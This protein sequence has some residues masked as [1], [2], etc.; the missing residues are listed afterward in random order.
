MSEAR[1]EAQLAA[2]VDLGF[3]RSEAVLIVADERRR[4]MV[5]ARDAGAKQREIAASLGISANCVRQY[6]ERARRMAGPWGRSNPAERLAQLGGSEVAILTPREKRL[7]W[8]AAWGLS[9]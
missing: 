9:G 8:R 2:W 1:R 5:R 6:E 3:S 4:S 7:M